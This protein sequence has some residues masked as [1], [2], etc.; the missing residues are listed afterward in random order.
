MN[1]DPHPHWS[2]CAS[3]IVFSDF[4]NLT[5]SAQGVAEVERTTA[6]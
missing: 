5:I 6:Y 4:F 2:P 1:F 3:D